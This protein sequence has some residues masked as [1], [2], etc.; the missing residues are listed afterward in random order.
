MTLHRLYRVLFGLLSFTLAAS[1]VAQAQGTTAPASTSQTPDYVGKAFDSAR[2]KLNSAIDTVNQTIEAHKVFRVRDE[3]IVRYACG[4]GK[5]LSVNY[6]FVN[7][8]PLAAATIGKQSLVFANVI[9]ASGA[10]YASGPY[11][12]WSKGNTLQIYDD[13]QSGAA[14]QPYRDCIEK[15]R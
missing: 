3:K 8:T 2:T 6:F 4:G 13:R 1:G 15:A 7:D 11:I 10:R 5:T 12:L 9:A 14:A